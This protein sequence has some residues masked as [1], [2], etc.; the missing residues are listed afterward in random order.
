MTRGTILLGIERSNISFVRFSPR[1]KKAVSGFDRPRPN[2]L[3]KNA[4]RGIFQ[5]RQVRS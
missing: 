2:S 5:P 3:L 4:V 1:N